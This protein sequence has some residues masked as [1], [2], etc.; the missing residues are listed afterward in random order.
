[1]CAMLTG[2]VP[3]FTRPMY[4]RMILGFVPA[5]R[6][7]VGFSISVG[8]STR[9]NHSK[10]FKP[11][12]P[13]LNAFIERYMRSMKDESLNKMIF[14]GEKS[15]RRAL[16]EFERGYVSVHVVNFAGQGTA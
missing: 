5:A 9:K 12:S 6:M 7:V 15:L 11:R 8:I 14:F 4:S 3:E 1:M 10:E 16:T 13:K 2:S